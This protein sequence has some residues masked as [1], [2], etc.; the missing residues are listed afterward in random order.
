[1][2]INELKNNPLYEFE[3]NISEE[4]KNIETDEWGCAFAWLGDNIGV[5]YNF[6]IDDGESYC[7]IYKTE[8]NNETD[9]IETD[10]DI[11]N[12]YDIDFDDE[13]WMNDLEDAMCVTLIEF[14]NL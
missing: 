5:E 6:C 12:H 7:A 3:C 8:I 13:N 1:M 9:Y 14:H 11:F 4:Y 2:T 10:Y